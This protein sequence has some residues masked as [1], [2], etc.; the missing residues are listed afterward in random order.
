MEPRPYIR[1]VVDRN[2]LMRPMTVFQ[3][4]KIQN[5]LLL[6]CYIDA[7]RTSVNFVLSLAKLSYV[8]NT[9][10]YTGFFTFI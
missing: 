2:V 4:V 6:P 5:M 10:T 9:N 3:T 8:L 1:T 7:A